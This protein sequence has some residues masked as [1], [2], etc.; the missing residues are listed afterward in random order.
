MKVYYRIITR[1][2][3]GT[4]KED[5]RKYGSLDQAGRTLLIRQPTYGIVVKVCE[6]KVLMIG[7]PVLDELFDEK[8]EAFS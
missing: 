3:N 8:K 6:E 5:D 4:K 2:A 1:E 7:D